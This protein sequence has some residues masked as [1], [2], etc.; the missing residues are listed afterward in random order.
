MYCC[1]C[2][3][4]RWG[5][6]DIPSRPECVSAVRRIAERLG[7]QAGLTRG[8]VDDLDLAVTEAC[9]NAIRHGSPDRERNTIYVTFHVG[10]ECVAVEIR[11]EGRGFDPTSKVPP[12][13]GEMRDGGYGLHIMRQVVD[14]VEI[15]SRGGTT[16]RLLKR[17]RKPQPSFLPG[18]HGSLRPAV[19]VG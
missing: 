3:I 15:S 10:P 14:R 6:L 13:P 5:Q 9:A 4:H 18:P 8:E 1:D 2:E 19:A 17:H 11:D 12:P 16:I 7:I